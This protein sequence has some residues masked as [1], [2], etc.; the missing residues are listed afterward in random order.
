MN[1]ARLREAL[2]RQGVHV[3]EDDPVLEV[4]AICELAMADSLKAIEAANQA[5]A[6]R[7][8]AAS[9]QHIEAARASASALITDSGAWAADHLRATA[10][11]IS[12]LIRQE[13]QA[14]TEKAVAAASLGLRAAWMLAAV[15]AAGLAAAVGFW[16]AGVR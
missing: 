7:I 1:P 3:S 11:E 10:A 12:Q 14:E 2:R 15:C 13:I 16:A 9:I 6:D 5:A 4:A 8:S